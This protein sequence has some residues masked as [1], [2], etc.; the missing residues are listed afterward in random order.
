M[1]RRNMVLIDEDKGGEEG[2]GTRLKIPKGTLSVDKIT[3]RKIQIN[4]NLP[5]GLL[6]ICRM[7]PVKSG[8]IGIVETCKGSN[9]IIMIMITYQQLGI[10]ILWL[11]CFLIN[12]V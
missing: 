1:H 10:F 8:V 12:K 4:L 3:L 9:I 2:E 6:T 11:L 7:L 5:I